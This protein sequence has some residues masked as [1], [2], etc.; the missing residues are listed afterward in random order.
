MKMAL[1]Q[2]MKT[3]LDEMGPLLPLLAVPVFSALESETELR[4]VMAGIMGLRLTV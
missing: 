4:T 3:R 1:A 2:A